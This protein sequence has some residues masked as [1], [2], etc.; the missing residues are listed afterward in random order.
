LKNGNARQ[1]TAEFSDIAATAPA[2]ETLSER[3]RNAVLPGYCKP[4]RTQ[5]FNCDMAAEVIR[6]IRGQ[7]KFVETLRARI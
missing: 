2:N 7:V 1:D 5:S 6:E 3:T 4:R